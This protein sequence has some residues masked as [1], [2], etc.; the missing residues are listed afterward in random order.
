[1][2]QPERFL[3]TVPAA[4]QAQGTVPAGRKWQAEYNVACWVRTR[5]AGTL[6]LQLLLRFT[7]DVGTH[8]V[9]IDRADCGGTGGTLLAGRPGV[10]V[11]G[12]ISEMSVWLLG[13]T[14][15]AVI[16]DELY[17]QRAGSAAAA[18]VAQGGR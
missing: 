16:V 4:T 10:Q 9:P 17:V 1:M 3:A 13:D 11:V 12:A 14:G 7:D 18:R 8:E 15:N 5:A 2:S 6:K